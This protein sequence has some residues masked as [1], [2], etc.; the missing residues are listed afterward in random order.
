[1]S[2][3]SWDDE[4]SSDDESPAPPAVNLSFA[5]RPPLNVAKAAAAAAS[6]EHKLPTES[7]Q[8]SSSSSSASS[9]MLVEST[10]APSTS[11]SQ[12]SVKRQSMRPSPLGS[13]AHGGHSPHEAPSARSGF[14]GLAAFRSPKGPLPKAASMASLKGKPAPSSPKG[15][16][17]LHRSETRVEKKSS[18]QS[19]SAA[20]KSGGFFSKMFKGGRSRDSGGSPSSACKAEPEEAD[21]GEEEEDGPKVRRTQSLHLAKGVAKKGMVN[22]SVGGSRGEGRGQEMS[23]AAGAVEFTL[24]QLEEGTQN[25]KEPERLL[26][27][28][29]VGKVYLGKLY[30]NEVAV[31][32]IEGSNGR[33]ISDLL[34]LGAMEHQCLAPLYGF[35]SERG[36]EFLIYEDVNPQTLES[37]LFP[38]GG[39]RHPGTNLPWSSRLNIALESAQGLAYLHKNKVVHRLVTSTNIMVDME[40]HARLSNYGLARVLDG[41][42]ATSLPGARGDLSTA[43]DVYAFGVVVL[44]L[45]TGR[46]AAQSGSSDRPIP[47]LVQWIDQDE[48]RRRD[49]RDLLDARL[50]AALDGDKKGLAQVSKL[51]QLARK[52]VADKKTARPQMTEVVKT[53]SKL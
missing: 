34:A 42:E 7:P 35:C 32:V 13:P 45:L 39:E 51:M 43:A 49:A 41:N 5:G 40:L 30:G 8:V 50:K 18:A 36:K 25:F 2:M 17:P 53:L 37:I 1:M 11:L 46:R 10:I 21:C 12:I 31:Q 4:S 27:E 26:S 52:C 14:L 16:S 24:V 47:E 33:D 38:Q 22:Y 28:D 23:R 20:H 44:E 29:E 6:G 3:E 15:T 9:H 19:P 48:Q